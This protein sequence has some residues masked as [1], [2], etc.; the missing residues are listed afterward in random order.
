M[1]PPFPGTGGA[2]DGALA[3]VPTTPEL[4]SLS[5]APAHDVVAV[6]SGWGCT[7]GYRTDSPSLGLGRGGRKTQGRLE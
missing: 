6:V 2:E 3:S 4:G 5:S 7:Q 1:L